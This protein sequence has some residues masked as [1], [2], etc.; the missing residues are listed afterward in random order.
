MADGVS[1]V[2]D[3]SR[4]AVVC[5]PAAAGAEAKAIDVLIEEVAKRT[6]IVWKRLHEAKAGVPVIVV[7]TAE[8]LKRLP[9]ADW[10]GAAEAAGLRPEGYVLQTATAADVGSE[11]PVVRI[12]GADERGVLYGVGKLLRQLRWGEGF[13]RLDKSLHIHTSPYSKLRGHQLGYRP[14]NN[15]FDAWTPEQFDLYIRELALFGANSIEIMPPRTDDR[16]TGPLMKV[17][18]LEMMIRLS[19]IIDSYGLDTWIWYPNMG[20][21][22]SD[23]ETVRTELAER[24]EIFSKLP[25]I[26]ALFV[27][28]SDP[29]KMEPDPLFAWMEQVAELLRKY[30][31]EAKIWLSP[32]IMTYHSAEWM[33]AFYRHVRREPDWLG[34]IVF[35]PHVDVTLPEL[36]RAIPERYPIRRYED[37]THNFHCQYPVADWDI[38][39][40]LTLG[41][42][43]CNPRP[44]AQKHIHN[45][46]AEYAIGNICYSEGINDDVN[47]FIWSDQDWDPATPVI[48]TLREYGRLFIDSERADAF[49]QGLLALER[50]WVGQ[51]ASNKDV[52]VTLQTWRQMEREATTLQRSNYRFQMHLLRAYFDA[53]TKRRLLY[54]TGLEYEAREALRGSGVSGSLAAV[55]AAERTLERA[56][57]EPVAADYRLRCNEL[58]DDLFA[59][60]GYQLTVSRHFARSQGRGAFIDAIDAPLND[61]RWLRTQFAQ[62]RQAGDE[63][64][65]LAMIGRLLDRTNPGPG[66]FYD[67][68]GS[69]GGFRRV[70]PGAG[71]AADPGYLQ[72]P[73]IAHA[74]YM[75]SMPEEQQQDLGG[76]PLAWVSHTNALLDTP[77][78]IRYDDLDPDTR[79]TFKAVFLGETKSNSSPRDCWASVN[80]N[81]AFV[82]EEEVFIAA[83]SVTVREMSVPPEAVKDG[84]L[85]LTI[86]RTRGYKRLNVAEVWLLRQN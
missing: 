70:D 53:Y 23:P 30:H 65:R 60:I 4:V 11:A 33:E 14:K 82:L 48:D 22:Y 47:K 19:G 67:P 45:V 49:A 83:G 39:Y 17:E 55:D 63:Y 68:L 59:S 73:R 85:K 12:V 13:V 40:A 20:D 5:S 35:G 3:L 52:E 1:T 36:R 71:W 78:D 32:Q 10:T 7:G 2:I 15:A 6:G 74:M 66:G 69:H 56:R 28:G 27:P 86:A 43:S 9:G 16:P 26:N 80:A 75:L 38:A 79:Y 54:E 72:S 29:G 64:E 21:D 31:P 81:D 77:I 50:N 51:L 34:G 61:I 37:I 58:A 24:E 84:K 46:L 76:V 18:P 25:R 57:T 8:R 44:Y 42:E 41:R 62:I